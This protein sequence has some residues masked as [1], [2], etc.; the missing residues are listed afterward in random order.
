MTNKKMKA[1]FLL[2]VIVALLYIYSV[3]NKLYR[4]NDGTACEVENCKNL[5]IEQ[6][7]LY[8]LAFVEFSERGNVFSRENFN[9]V[10]SHIKS[11]EKN[12]GVM[13]VVYAHG[14]K[15]NA[16]GKTGDVKKF[17][18]ALVS[19]SKVSKQVSP[20]KV[21]GLYIGW[22][23]ESLRLPL[24]D[25][26]TYWGRKNV[27][28][29]VGTGGVSELLIRLNKITKNKTGS[30]KN[31]FVI[32]GHSFGGA[33]ILS[34]MKDIL[35]YHT[36]NT[37]KVPSNTCK[38]PTVNFTRHCRA[39]CYK[40]EAFSDSTILINPAIEANELL[41][42]K[43]IVSEKRCYSR[44]QPKL[45]HILSSKADNATGVAF[46]VGQKI[47]VSVLTAE[48]TLER[49]VHD[50]D[51]DT[52]GVDSY[53]KITISEKELDII[54]IGN[55]PKFR[56]GIYINNKYIACRGKGECIKEGSDLSNFPVSPFEPVSIIYTD[57]NFIKNHNDI[58]NPKVL[59]Y[60]TSA[61][62]E[63]QDKR[64]IELKKFNKINSL[65][66]N[67]KIFRF[68]KCFDN[69]HTIYKNVAEKTANK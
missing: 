9:K 5:L 50:G 16:G 29:Q 38:L 31:V 2:S 47:G 13:L 52:N 26:F 64:K 30:I 55:Y 62:I 1:V 10:L 18:K 67:D 39:G 35:I 42:I 49:K 14:W 56:T 51:P 11:E 23:G 21:I 7:D 12:S 43:E 40:G 20:R 46:L 54:T 28:R 15:H 63:N 33:L 59:A 66:F 19:L 6:H 36:L 65:C 61:V 60:I 58:S 25:F 48:A 8:D 34:A 44:E 37:K 22:R 4:G 27:A 32:S 3:P 57:E 41:Q 24:I 17:R 69:F 53:K 45:L 68:K